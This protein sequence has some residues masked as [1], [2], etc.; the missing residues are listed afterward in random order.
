MS[1]ILVAEHNV[2][3]RGLMREIM[4]S[5]GHEVIEARD[6]QEALDKLEQTSLDLVLLDTWLAII[7]KAPR[8][9]LTMRPY[10]PA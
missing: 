1:K 6:G 2:P 3:N 8:S 4:E 10:R 9:A 5:R 7:V